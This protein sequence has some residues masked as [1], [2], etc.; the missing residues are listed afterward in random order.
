MSWLCCVMRGRKEREVMPDLE[1]VEAYETLVRKNIVRI[2]MRG[3]P[4]DGTLACGTGFIVACVQN[5]QY[6]DMAF[7]VTAGHVLKEQVKKG[8]VEVT[9]IREKDDRDGSEKNRIAR[10]AWTKGT[11]EGPRLTYYIGE[12][13]VDMGFMLVPSEC[14]DGEKFIGEEEF[15]GS[16]GAPGIR[17]IPR[18]VIIGE[19][20]RVAWAGY[21]AVARKIFG[22]PTLCYY[23]GVVAHCR[24]HPQQPMYLL[25]GHN[26][27]G[28]SGGPVWWWSEDRKQVEVIGIIWAYAEETMSGFTVATPLNP[29]RMMFDTIWLRRGSEEGLEI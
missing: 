26:D 1:I 2:E 22:E 27:K 17:M 19:G 18:D 25:D 3:V 14:V 4:G 28:V 24:N 23:E 15:T 16:G 10:F 12:P 9:V 11:K 21:P 7:V 8:D 29:F 13:Q 5:A 20:A 6:G